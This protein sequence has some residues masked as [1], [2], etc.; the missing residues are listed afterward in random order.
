L[1]EQKVPG[2]HLYTLN[3]SRPT[4]KILNAVEQAQL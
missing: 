2:V 1:V 4:L 3:S